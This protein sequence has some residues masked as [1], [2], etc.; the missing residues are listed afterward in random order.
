M[1]FSFF[2]ENFRNIKMDSPIYFGS[3]V[4]LIFGI[5]GS[6]KTNFCNAIR[7]IFFSATESQLERDS[8]FC[9]EFEEMG[10][11]IEFSYRREKDGSI[12]SAEVRIK[13]R[14]FCYVCGKRDSVPVN[15]LKEAERFALENERAD[16][17]PCLERCERVISQRSFCVMNENCENMHLNGWNKPCD[18]IGKQRGQT[19][20][21]FVA[22]LIVDD[23]D[24][25]ENAGSRESDIMNKPEQMI[26]FARRSKWIDEKI[27]PLDNYYCMK[28]GKP[29]KMISLME[30]E[31]ISVKQLK[32]LFQKGVFEL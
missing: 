26:L 8:V 4:T 17:R 9:Y 28:N 16:V 20:R 2:V 6:G 19:K 10:N 21:N 11:N 27:A 1:L 18:F 12:R 32:N 25:I 7:N 13:K 24:Y 5:C 3:G 29:I 23:V 22:T 31:I 14:D 30:K 15:I